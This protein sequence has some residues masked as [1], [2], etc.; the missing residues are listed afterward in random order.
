MNAIARYI[1]RRMTAPPDVVIGGHENPY[2]LRWWIIPRNPFFNIYGHEFRRSD[3]DRALHTHP[4][5]F[6]IS[7]V[8]R[9]SYWEHTPQGVSLR[10]RGSV[11]FRWG[12][13][14]HRVE[15]FKFFGGPEH[16]CRTLFITGPRVREWGFLCPQGF[17]HWKDF[18]APHDA[19]EIGRGCE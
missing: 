13:S 2:L 7:I 11:V 14:P 4:W 9:G 12:A 17:R 10:R 5:L 3:D 1:D 19:G 6:N 16:P 18:T 8:W 15:L